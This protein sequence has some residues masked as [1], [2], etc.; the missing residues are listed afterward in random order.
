VS[1]LHPRRTP[2][3]HE[4]DGCVASRSG[5][6]GAGKPYVSNEKVMGGEGQCTVKHL[7]C[8]LD[9]KSMC[10]QIEF[11]RT[12]GCLMRGVIKFFSD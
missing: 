10:K 8:F 6:V 4:T 3:V 2:C 1:A 12:F 11:F 9:V 7:E 5:L